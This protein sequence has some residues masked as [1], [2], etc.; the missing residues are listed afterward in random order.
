MSGTTQPSATGHPSTTGPSSGSPAPRW[1]AAHELRTPLQ[2]I[3]GGVELLLEAQGAGL[4][5]ELLDVVTLIATAATDLESQLDL[6]A[7]LAALADA[8]RPAPRVVAL[9]DL[10]ALPE[11]ARAL[12]PPPPVAGLSPT[13][14]VLVAP[15]PF[16]RAMT[17][18]AAARQ[19]PRGPLSCALHVT[20]PTD[21]R[22]ELGFV[23]C[24]SGA[25]SV[26]LR[27]ARELLA[28]AVVLSA[29]AAM[30]G[31]SSRC[32]AAE[33]ARPARRP[34]LRLQRNGARPTGGRGGAGPSFHL[35]FRPCR[36]KVEG[37]YEPSI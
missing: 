22:L 15:E 2:A 5:P 12:A 31:S 26:A 7:E 29:P 1:F 4:R 21:I 35:I 20:G 11:V 28:L 3:K 33:V 34:W 16:G 37:S 27:L 36:V 17:L 14:R 8:P 32:V 13:L 24:G 23:A 10:L 18:L 6:M 9:A 25:G 19:G 30:P